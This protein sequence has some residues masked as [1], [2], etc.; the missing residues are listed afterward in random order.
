M[1]HL[2][3]L[4]GAVL[5]V[6]GDPA[7][8]RAAQ[9]YH[10]AVLAILAAAPARTVSRDKLVGLLWAESGGS[11][12]RHR[13]SVALHVLR[14]ELGADAIISSGDALALNPEVVW[15]DVDAFSSSAAQRSSNAGWIQSGIDS[16]GSIAPPWR[17]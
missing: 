13:L 17:G 7:T 11:K 8:G 15:T 10:L 6:D 1:I 14:K 4:G 5:Q 9:P 3:V 16:R 12:A 2:R